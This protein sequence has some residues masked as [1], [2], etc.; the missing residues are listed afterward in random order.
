MRK[1]ILVL[2]AGGL[3]GGHLCKKLMQEGHY[4]R[5][6]DQTP[7]IYFGTDFVD[8]WRMGDLRNKNF[9]WTVFDMKFDEVYQLAAD[10]G[11]AGYIFTGE[12]DADVMSN[13]MAINLNVLDVAWRTDTPGVFFSSSACVYPEHA[14]M[15]TV[16]LSLVE[17]SAYPAA[18][19]SEYGWEKLFAERLYLAYNKNH[20]MSNS[21]GRYHNVYGTHCAY[22]N[23]KEKAPAAIARKVAQASTSV[24]PSNTIKIWGDGQ[25][26]R[27]FLWVDDAVD[28]TLLLHRHPTFRGPVNIGSEH[29]VTIDELVQITMIAADKQLDIAHIPGPTGVAARTSNNTLVEQELGWR[30]RVPLHVGMSMLYNWVEGEVWAHSE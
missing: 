25:Q 30:P 21:V 18:P 12:N 13:S 8:S 11:G 1:N 26:T 28:A 9:V 5:G 4:V 17:E 24:H 6:V 7:H 3:I 29:M 27:S 14:Q 10:M 2:G 22:A 20:G 16:G 15:S 19:D 23:G